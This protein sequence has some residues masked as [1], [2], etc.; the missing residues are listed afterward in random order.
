MWNRTMARSTANPR[1]GPY[2]P[3]VT[4]DSVK[5]IRSQLSATNLL[6]L[7]KDLAPLAL[8]A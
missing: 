4:L 1:I 5:K 8:A 3:P 2:A 6:A 7:G